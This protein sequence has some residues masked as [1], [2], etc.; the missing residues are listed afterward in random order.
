MSSVIF[1]IPPK[2]R[3]KSNKLGEPKVGNTT[4]VA[5]NILSRHLLVYEVL[6]TDWCSIYYSPGLAEIFGS[7]LIFIGYPTNYVTNFRVK[8]LA[9]SRNLFVLLC[10]D[11]E[12]K[13]K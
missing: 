6:V 7:T 12:I 4:W 3:W 13:F 8:Y 1:H 2:A 5:W 10:E 9:G 11:N